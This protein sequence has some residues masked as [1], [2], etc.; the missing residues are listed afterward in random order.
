[1]IL[2]NMDTSQMGAK[3]I[4]REEERSPIIVAK[5]ASIFDSFIFIFW[6]IMCQSQCQCNCQR[7]MEKA[8]PSTAAILHLSSEAK[9]QRPRHTAC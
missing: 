4:Q 1:M 9:G 3:F 5:I 6:A 2:T 7:K 8:G